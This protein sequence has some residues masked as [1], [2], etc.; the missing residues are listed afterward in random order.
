[1]FLHFQKRN[2]NVRLL[3]ALELLLSALPADISK[4]MA[5]LPAQE[6]SQMRKEY[7]KF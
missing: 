1:M 7:L 2:E 3:K 5:L 4:N 6:I